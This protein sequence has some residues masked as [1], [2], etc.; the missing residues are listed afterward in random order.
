MLGGE[1]ERFRSPERSDTLL[2]LPMVAEAEFSSP[3]L[4]PLECP[5]R[6]DGDRREF[7]WRNRGDVGPLALEWSEAFAGSILCD[8]APVRPER[9]LRRFDDQCLGVTLPDSAARSGEHKLIFDGAWIKHTPPRLGG[10]VDVGLWTDRPSENLVRRFYNLEIRA[11]RRK[12]LELAPR[13]RRLFAGT[14]LGSQGQLFYDGETTFTWRFTLAEAASLID[15]GD[16]R[17]ICEV[18]LDVG[19][20]VRSIFSPRLVPMRISA[21]DHELRITLYGSLGASLEGGNADVRLGRDIRICR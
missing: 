14:S 8:G 10:D 16:T 6:C 17:G 20:K 4:I 7:V 13:R 21:G 5:D 2:T 11:P 3:Q 15:L 12:V 9:S 18:V 19:E 1:F